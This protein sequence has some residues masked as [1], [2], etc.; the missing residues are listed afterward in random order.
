M[1]KSRFVPVGID[2][3]YQFAKEYASLMAEKITY[4]IDVDKQNPKKAE[5]FYVDRERMIPV[6]G[7]MLKICLPK[8]EFDKLIENDMEVDPEQSINWV[9]KCVVGR[10]TKN[11]LDD[12][13][14]IET[15]SLDIMQ[16]SSIIYHMES[17]IEMQMLTLIFCYYF[18]DMWAEKQGYG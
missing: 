4:Q 3:S 11:E 7:V 9:R 16:N 14:V 5:L 12:E 15:N 18:T 8:E 13:R 17:V 6:E 1:I 10:I 2:N